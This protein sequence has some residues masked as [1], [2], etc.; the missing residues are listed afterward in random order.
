MGPERPVA[1]YERQLWG[2]LK[3]YEAAGAA[4]PPIYIGIGSEDDLAPA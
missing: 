1:D 2:W 4:R 3:R